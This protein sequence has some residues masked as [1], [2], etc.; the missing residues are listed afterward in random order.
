MPGTEQLIDDAF[1]DLALA[2]DELVRAEF[3]ELIAA[4]WESPYEPPLDKSSPPARA[5]GAR[6]PSRR[7]RLRGRRL[8]CGPTRRPLGR[9]RGPPR[10]RSD[11]TR[12]ETEV[13]EE[14]R[15]TSN[16]RTI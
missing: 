15:S 10:R 7:S 2:D 9:G 11:R 6:P 4:C 13:L 5:W 12:S 8:G 14:V 16:R 3:D 1:V